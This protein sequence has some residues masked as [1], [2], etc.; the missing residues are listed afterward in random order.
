MNRSYLDAALLD[1]L[2]RL[3]HLHRLFWLLMTPIFN[4]LEK[5]SEVE[6]IQEALRLKFADELTI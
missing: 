1:S 4:S 3:S 6:A 5:G 2:F